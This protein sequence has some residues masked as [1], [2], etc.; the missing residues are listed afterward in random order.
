MKDTLQTKKD[1]NH[2]A[3]VALSGSIW[4]SRRWLAV[5]VAGAAAWLIF[6]LYGSCSSSLRAFDP[7]E[8]ARLEA[9][10]WRSYYAKDHLRLFG[11][12]AELLRRQYHL[13]FGRSNLLAYY[14]ARA[15]FVFKEGKCLAGYQK[16]MP[17]LIRFYTAIRRVSDT[18]FDVDRAAKLELRWWIA[19]RERA[20]HV[21]QDPDRALAEWSAEV[22]R[23]PMSQMI[24]PA[25]LRAEAMIIRDEKAEKGGLSET[26]WRRIEELLGV[27][28]TSLWQAVNSGTGTNDLGRHS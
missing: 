11:Q 24:Q 15:A 23:V 17:S 14:A 16:A 4:R 27:S 19:H 7:N 18:S 3:T 25:R 26:D 21:P 1:R 20:E 22:Y 13:P 12:L 9:A 8:V 2:P 28:W 5:L 6:D 10:M